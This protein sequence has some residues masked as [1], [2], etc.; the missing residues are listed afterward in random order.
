MADILM[1]KYRSLVLLVCVTMINAQTAGVHMKVRIRD[2]F[3]VLLFFLMNR[4]QDANGAVMF[5]PNGDVSLFRA[6]SG[7]LQTDG[8]LVVAG[9]AEE[10]LRCSYFM[11]YLQETSRP[12]TLR[13]T[14]CRSLHNKAL[15]SWAC[16]HS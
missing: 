1:I 16:K 11:L 3:F 8:S 7:T 2:Y 6:G 4:K 10:V 9:Q 5:G 14:S 12:A 13:R 15:R